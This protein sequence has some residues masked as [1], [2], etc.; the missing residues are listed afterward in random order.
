MASLKHGDRALKFIVM[1]PT[2]LLALRGVSV[3]A[4]GV[5][6]LREINLSMKQGETLLVF[7]ESGSGKS[8]I[9]NVIGDCIPFSGAVVKRE[10]V[11]E[12]TVGI[13][14]DTLAAFPDLKVQDIVK[15]YGRIRS[16]SENKAMLQI[17]RL[18]EIE[19]RRFRAL[20][21]GERRRLALY[22]A[23][24]F[25]PLLAV[26][27]EP[28]EGLDPMQRQAFWRLVQER[29]G[30]TVVVTH[31]WEEALSSQGRICL[32]ASGR[33]LGDAR[34]LEDWMA[35]VSHK[36][37]FAWAQQGEVDDTEGLEEFVTLATHAHTNLYYDE[38]NRGA[39]L[40]VV[41]RHSATYSESLIGL[42]DVYLLLKAGL[43][44]R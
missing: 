5:P 15:M 25:D 35:M 32:L 26:L 36:G 13:S 33:M 18:D 37:R 9:V 8:T 1:Q 17:F 14:H 41:K 42:E 16:T 38:G 4:Q 6:V 23:L 21:T 39:A 10:D 19:K 11:T 7:G 28:T 27:D 12:H 40:E 24:F 44:A 30:A 20:S 2:D 29:E 31:L 3:E 43:I 22:L 34:L